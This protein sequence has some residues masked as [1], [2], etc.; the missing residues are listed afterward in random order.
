MI[1]PL[2][3]AWYWTALGGYTVGW[4]VGYMLWGRE[5]A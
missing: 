2:D 3:E 1:W 5:A 4:L